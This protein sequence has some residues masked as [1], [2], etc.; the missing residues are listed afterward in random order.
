MSGKKEFLHTTPFPRYHPNESVGTIKW[1]IRQ[2]HVCTFLIVQI[3]I[4]TEAM[5]ND[6]GVLL[7]LDVWAT[8]LCGVCP[9]EEKAHTTNTKV[10]R[11]QHCTVTQPCH[12]PKLSQQDREAKSSTLSKKVC[13]LLFLHI[14]FD[15]FLAQI[16]EP[17][18]IPTHTIS[19][20][21]GGK[22]GRWMVQKEKIFASAENL[23]GPYS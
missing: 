21:C 16:D 7:H 19:H 17:S 15:A 6:E 14:A 23:N 13:S 10:C 9:R 22:T 18:T 8:W 5:R 4:H 20:R 11:E 3:W 1:N 12:I 2:Y